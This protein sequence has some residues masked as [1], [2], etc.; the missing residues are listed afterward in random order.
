M[1]TA[2]LTPRIGLEASVKAS[3]SSIPEV[4][5]GLREI[6]GARLVA[7]LGGVKETRTVREWADGKRAPSSDSVRRRLR[8]AYQVAV[9]LH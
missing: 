7:Y 3:R 1:T 9:M 5:L 4:I 6:L 8:D 2:P